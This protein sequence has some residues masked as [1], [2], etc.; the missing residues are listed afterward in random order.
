MRHYPDDA[1]ADT[2]RSWQQISYGSVIA[3]VSLQTSGS[4]DVVVLARLNPLVS[5]DR[6]VMI[7]VTNLDLLLKL[8]R[9]CKI[10]D[11][12]N[13]MEATGAGWPV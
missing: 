6:D 5:P 8:L 12:K 7:Q 9:V 13:T 4:S 10:R 11:K 2:A 3:F 1:S